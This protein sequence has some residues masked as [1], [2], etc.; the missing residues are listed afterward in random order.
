MN[1]QLIPSIVLLFGLALDTFPAGAAPV[2]VVPDQPGLEFTLPVSRLHF[3]MGENR[4]HHTLPV[5][6]LHFTMPEED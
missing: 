3:T 5:S 4:L 1:R 2:V 6:R